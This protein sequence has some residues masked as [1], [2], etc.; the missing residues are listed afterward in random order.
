MC[1]TLV[2]EFIVLEPAFACET[3]LWSRMAESTIGV[4]FNWFAVQITLHPASHSQP[5]DI[6]IL[7]FW[8]LFIHHF[9]GLVLHLSIFF[10]PLGIFATSCT[11]LGCDPEFHDVDNRLGA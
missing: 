6:S 9:K 1:Q 3:G 10:V 8:F 7:T 2:M 11:L 4:W 5:L